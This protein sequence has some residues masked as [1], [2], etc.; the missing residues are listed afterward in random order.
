MHILLFMTSL[1]QFFYQSPQQYVLTDIYS[2]LES[3]SG[4]SYS[5][6]TTATTASAM[7]ANTSSLSN[8]TT[9]PSSRSSNER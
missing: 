5:Y 4:L 8:G 1:T 9:S 3:H 6:V 2:W 7:K